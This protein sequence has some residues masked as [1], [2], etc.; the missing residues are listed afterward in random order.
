MHKH[1]VTNFRNLMANYQLLTFVIPKTAIE[2][3][4]GKI[5][6]KIDFVLNMEGHRTEKW[7]KEI[8]LDFKHLEQNIDMIISRADWAELEDMSWKSEK[9][10]F[11]HDASID[12]DI[13]NNRIEEFQFR[14][15]L[16]DDTLIFLNQMLN[17]LKKN[18]FILMD[19]KGYLCNPNL[20]ELRELITESDSYTYLKNLVA[21]N[22]LLKDL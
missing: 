1:V 5:P 21:S 14:T 16:R 2:K 22:K 3:E 19:Q 8:S 12:F 11:D 17:L 13:K 6:S 15:D 4:F 7:W 10:K 18:E 9:T 20:K